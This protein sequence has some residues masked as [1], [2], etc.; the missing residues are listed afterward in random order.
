MGVTT[1]TMGRVWGGFSARNVWGGF[2]TGTCGEGCLPNMCV[3]S[4]TAAAVP[5]VVCAVF[6]VFGVV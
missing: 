3:I 5:A 4:Y 6:G 2:S 1:S